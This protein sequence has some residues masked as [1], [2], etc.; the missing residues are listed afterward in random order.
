MILAVHDPGTLP[1]SCS[2]STTHAATEKRFEKIAKTATE[3]ECF[4][5]RTIAELEMNILPARRRL[6]VLSCLPV[7]S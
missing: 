1:S 5:L 2:S 7:R 3:I 6:E 4:C